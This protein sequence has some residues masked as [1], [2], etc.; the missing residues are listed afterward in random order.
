MMGCIPPVG[1]ERA[2]PKAPALANPGRGISDPARSRSPLEGHEP[3]LPPPHPVS[4]PSFLG[5]P[6]LRNEMLVP[7]FDWRRSLR[8][9]SLRRASDRY[10]IRRALPSKRYSARTALTKTPSAAAAPKKISADIHFSA[11]VAPHR[12]QIG[13]HR[14]P[15]H[16]AILRPRVRRTLRI[17][18]GDFGELES[19][20]SF[21]DGVISRLEGMSSRVAQEHSA[22]AT[23]AHANQF[24]DSI[25]KI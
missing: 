2:G 24:R 23:Q 20:G 3:Q 17:S 11:N 22:A 8:R 15:H 14:G 10:L 21:D 25:R 1:D 9:E 12:F 7:Y 18:H 4:V 19:R 5:G 16:R 6:R 13:P